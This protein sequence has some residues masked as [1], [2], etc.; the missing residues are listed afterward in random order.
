MLLM[1]DVIISSCC[2]KINHWFYKLKKLLFF[3]LKLLTVG[4]E[5][6]NTHLRIIDLFT[7]DTTLA[8]YIQPNEVTQL[9]LEVSEITA[10]LRFVEWTTH[11]LCLFQ[12]FVYLIKRDYFERFRD[13]V[14]Q[15]VPPMLEPSS[16]PPTAFAA[17]LFEFIYR[18]LKLVSLNCDQNYK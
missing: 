2:K 8:K 3:H 17:S 11:C 12:V 7:S 14:D 10:L 15:R 9:L 5:T 18:P 16:E 6:L 4:R 1:P 13:V